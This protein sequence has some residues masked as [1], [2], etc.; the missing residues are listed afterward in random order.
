[1]WLLTGLACS[2]VDEPFDGRP[3]GPVDH[4]ASHDD[5]VVDAIMH[6]ARAWE[7]DVLVAI[8]P[9]PAL[10]ADFA[11]VL[12]GL[13]ASFE[14]VDPR[15]RIAFTTTALGGPELGW[16]ATTG[17]DDGRWLS[18][19]DLLDPSIDWTGAP[20]GEPFGATGA[21]FLAIDTDTYGFRRPEAALQLIV[22]ARAPDATPESVIAFQDWTEWVGAEDAVVFAAVPVG[23]P[24]LDVVVITGGV[25]GD[26]DASLDPWMSQVAI[27]SQNPPRTYPLSALPLRGT[28]EVTVEDV[29]RDIFSFTEAVGDPPVGDWT[30]DGTANAIRFLEYV[31][32]PLSIVFAN[33]VP[34]GDFDPDTTD[35]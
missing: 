18:R 26:P 23:D 14:Q 32:E 19:E 35:R 27:A 16:L 31:P 3:P 12:P 13:L 15:W 2:Y 25:V 10:W 7:L 1:M 28:I 29:H 24:L 17:N 5:I 8:E 21:T 11:E 4:P 6:G 34:L 20:H 30:F 9:D 22:V 33:Y